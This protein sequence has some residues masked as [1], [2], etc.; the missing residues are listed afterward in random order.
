MPSELSLEKISDF[1][2][3]WMFA[4]VR[5]I[6]NC[7]RLLSIIDEEERRRA[8]SKL[9]LMS[10]V[11]SII[12][13]LPLSHRYGIEWN[14][15]GFDVCFLLGFTT[16][17]FTSGFAIQVGLR[18]RRIRSRLSDILAIYTAFVVCYEPLYIVASYPQSH[19][20]FDGLNDSKHKGMYFLQSL[21]L[22]FSQS[23]ATE[24]NATDVLSTVCSW[25]LLLAFCTSTALIA[26]TIAEK[27][28]ATK[29]N[30]FSAI[31][32]ASAA[33][34][35]PLAVVQSLVIA[36]IVFSFMKG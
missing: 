3:D 4:V 2:F 34:L 15:A 6:D 27:C 22:Y 9:W 35:A 30:S 33:V 31:T 12:T 13:Y 36:Y 18:L 11:I 23:L 28:G 25:V 17:M 10:V 32:F 14:T 26:R 24:V 8:I 5:P 1:V 29:L 20:L 7:K 21:E 19:R 16:I